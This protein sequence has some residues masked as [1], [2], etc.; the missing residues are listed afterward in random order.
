[1][2]LFLEVALSN[3]QRSGVQVAVAIAA[4][5]RRRQASVGPLLSLLVSGTRRERVTS[6]RA[7]GWR[8]AQTAIPLISA[9]LPD[10]EG[11]EGGAG[12]RDREWRVRVAAAKAMA[13]LHA[14]LSR[15]QVATLLADPHRAV[16]S[17]GLNRLPMLSMISDE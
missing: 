17:E 16:R 5:L 10:R 6:S 7:L 9:A 11:R 8:G 1:P 15:A 4:G 14:P 2:D 12:L 13:A 3:P